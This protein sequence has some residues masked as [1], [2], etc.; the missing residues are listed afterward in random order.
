MRTPCE[1]ID[2]ITLTGAQLAAYRRG[3]YQRAFSELSKLM[4]SYD[5][6][7]KGDPTDASNY[8]EVEEMAI[9][10]DMWAVENKLIDTPQTS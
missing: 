5:R 3:C 10:L 8:E 1:D 6:G 4:D 9:E 2:P 7:D